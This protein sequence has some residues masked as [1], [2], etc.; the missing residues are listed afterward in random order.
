MI[1]RPAL[2][3]R[4]RGAGRQGAGRQGSPRQGARGRSGAPPDCPMSWQQDQPTTRD[5]ANP[6]GRTITTILVIMIAVMIVR[7]IFVRRW[8]AAT[9]PPADVTQRSRVI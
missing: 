1:C 5:A 4:I 6:R 8:G 7:D 3:C 9:P 2:A